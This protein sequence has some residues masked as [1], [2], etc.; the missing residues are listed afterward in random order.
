MLRATLKGVL[1]HKIRLLLTALAVVLGVAFVAGTYV[2]TDTL[3]ATFDN[4]F[5][6]VTA[7]V[8]VSVR[9]ESGFGDETS[10]IT[11]RDTVPEDLRSVVAAVDGI[12][13]A[14]GSLAGYAQYVD[15]EGEA[16]VTGGAPNL[17]VNWTDIPELNPLRLREGRAPRGPTEVLMDAGT[18]K[19]HDF[20]V[21]DT[22]RILFQGPPGDFTVVGIAGFG[23]ADNLAGATLA[24]FDTPTTQRVL[25]KVGRFDTVDAVGD[26]TASPLDLRAGSRTPS[27]TATRPSPAARWPTS[28]RSRS[29][30]RSASSTPSCWSS[31]ASPSSSAPSSSSTPSRSWWP[32]APG[33]WPCC[34]PSVPAGGRCWRPSSGRRPSSA[35]WRRPPAWAWASS[36]PSASRA[37]WARSASTCPV[38]T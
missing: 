36:S 28:S 2:L 38:A 1:A 22:V 23:E 11:G 33:N 12:E 27:P 10:F 20:R 34:G 37:C 5:D 35:W 32:S 15:K 30:R 17:G 19:E 9:A 21:G 3:N 16:I 25:N 24:V 29:R 18:A 14:D 4:L 13:A 6:E 26:G 8:D 31:P 7:G